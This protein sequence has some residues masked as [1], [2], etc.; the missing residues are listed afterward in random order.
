MT[1]RAVIYARYG[2]DTVL[3]GPSAVVG[4][5]KLIADERIRV[6]TDDSVAGDHIRRL[7]A[8][9]RTETIIRVSLSIVG[10]NT[11]LMSRGV[12]CRSVMMLARGRMGR[13]GSDRER[14]EHADEANSNTVR[15]CHFHWFTSSDIRACLMAKAKNSQ[16]NFAR[17]G[18]SPLRV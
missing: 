18:H 11:G 6:A 17:H 8:D 7:H 3:V 1:I 5:E 2:S 16:S 9:E 14:G 12:G 10:R 13:L 4:P 15:R